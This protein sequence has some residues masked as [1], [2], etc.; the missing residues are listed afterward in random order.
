MNNVFIESSNIISSL[1]WNTRENLDSVLAGKTGIKITQD[2][3]LSDTD[4]PASLIDTAGIENRFADISSDSSFT[5]FEKLVILSIHDA[6]SKSGIQSDDSKTILILCS[7]K[8]NVELLSN[9]KGFDSNRLMLWKS[10]DLI[11]HFFDMRKQPLVVSNACIS[12]VVGMLLAMRL[13][14]NGKYDKAVV[15]GADVLSKFIVSGFQSFQSLS[16]QACRPFDMSRDGLSLGEGVGT[17]IISKQNGA[18]EIVD[19][20][21]S[22]DANHISGPSRTGEGLLVSIQKTL[23]NKT[24][25]LISAH[26]TATPYNDDMESVAISRAGLEKVAVNSLKGCFGHTLGAAGVIESIINIEAMKQ[27]TMVGT[28]GFSEIGLAKK[29][30]VVDKNLQTEYNTILKTASGF[31]GCNA[32]ALFRL[33]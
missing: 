29:I 1:G 7:T 30:N 28:M 16:E 26:G 21:I 5:R 4:F 27:D 33:H 13:I 24:V 14:R 3:Q 17:V 32:S 8:G 10:A 6:L 22:N 12:G 2:R 11:A 20:A 25:D 9:L 18:V 23:D 19:G 15:A 31:G